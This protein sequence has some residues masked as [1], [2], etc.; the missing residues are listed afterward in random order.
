[1]SSYQ[2]QPIPGPILDLGEG[3][4]WDAE[5]QSLY[6]VNLFQAEVLRL[7]YPT[8]QVFRAR[9]DGSTHATFIIPVK[10][11]HD[12]FII[13]DG[14]RIVLIQWDGVS[15]VA[16][17]IEVIATFGELEQTNRWNDGKADCH[18]RLFGGTMISEMQG[19]P[20]ESNTGNFY[21]F[22]A[23]QLK[24]T[25]LISNVF[26]SNGLAWNYNTKKFYYADSG[27]FE[28][29]EFDFDA[30]GNLSNGKVWF[31]F[32]QN[33]QRP[34]EFPDGMTIDDQGN[35]YVAV[36][37]AAKVLKIN[38]SGQ[39]EMEIQTPASQVTSVAFGGPQLDELYV[40]T[41][42]RQDSGIPLPEPA[43]AT[44]RV[45]GLGVRGTPMYQV[46]L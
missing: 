14:N 19:N 22:E 30:E 11:K 5:R 28:I 27:A 45:T 9:V 35:L 21:R 7:D 41:A 24:F 6:Y 8:N 29:K 42:S 25:R 37:H 26:I 12:Q 2:V 10:N 38:P 46:E 34:V 1:M 44:F 39:V 15:E 32:K 31:D 4:H 40:T 36:F 16:R 33:G 13:G 18:G 17:S 23:N 43:G 20:F 3:P